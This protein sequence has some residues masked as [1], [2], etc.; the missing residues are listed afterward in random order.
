MAEV[1]GT[2]NERSS[3][4][5]IAVTTHLDLDDPRYAEAAAAIL[6]RHDLYEAEANITSAV[7]DFLLVT[8]LVSGD[9]I[10]EEVRPAEGSREAVDLTV[11]RTFIEV[12]RRI[13]TGRGA[14]PDPQNIRQ[15][16]DYLA[17]AEAEGHVFRMG[18]LTD[19]RHWLLRWPGAGPV[20]TT[21]PHAF[22]LDN[23]G[24]WFLLYEWLRDHALFS[25]TKIEPDRAHVARSFGPDSP[26]YERE[27]AAFTRLYNAGAGSATVRIKRR[28]WGDLLRAA[29]GEVA[30]RPD[31]MDDLFIR[32]TYL[33]AVIG[34]AVQASFGVDI[35]QLAQDDPA[36]LLLGQRFQNYTGLQGIVESDF[37]TWPLEV[38]GQPALRALAQRVAHFDWPHAPADTAAILYETVIPPAERRQLGEYYTPPWLAR[39]MVEEVVSDPLGQ[40]VLDPACGSGTFIAEAVTHVIDAAA[41][42]GLEPGATLDRLRASVT[43]MD[44]HPVAV[45]LARAAWALAARPAIQAAA[46]AGSTTTVSVP[47]YL[48]DAL[49]MR[50]RNGDMFSEHEVTLPVDDERNSELVFPVRLVERADAFDLLMSDIATYIEHGEDPVV[51]LDDHHIIDASE[52]RIMQTT[53]GVMRNLHAA[54]RNHIWAY[55]T[56][57]LVRPVALARGKVDVIIGNP[58]WLNYNKTAST[59]RLALE[60]QSKNLYGIWAGGRYATHQ[61]VAGLFF[62]RCVDLYLKDGGMIGMVMP[63][64]ALQTGQYSKW[65]SGRWVSKLSGIVVDFGWKTAWDLE[66]LDPNTFFPVAASVVFAR[67]IGD[68]GTSVALEGEVERWVGKAGASNVRRIRT[69]IMD[70]SVAGGSPYAKVSRQGATIV[71]RRLFF[72]EETEN[73]AIVQAGQTI[74]VKPRLSS[75]DKYPWNRIDLTGLTEQT[76]ENEHVFDVHMGETLAPYV[77]LRPLRAVLPLK[78]TDFSIARD[79]NGVGGV[80]IASLE[81]RMRNRW[82]IVSR[83]R[84]Q[85]KK[86]SDRLDAL[87]RLDFHGELS[88]QLKWR[89]DPGDRPVRVVYTSSGEP[90]AALL[91]DSDVIV[92]YKLFWISCKD[93]NEAYYLMSIIN[94]NILAVAVNKYTTPNWAGKTR[95]L[96]KQLWKLPIPDFDPEDALHMDIVDAGQAAEHGAIQELGSLRESRGFTGTTS[97]IARR[98]LRRWLESSTAGREVE[99]VVS[100]LIS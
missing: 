53:I 18:V 100:R 68:I 10:H 32:H 37:F 76:I 23:P 71:P 88:A 30:K 82:R 72:V 97:R 46:R 96:Q 66:R 24:R 5:H 7:R 64:S 80:R 29:L 6:R 50:F 99:A 85:H 86:S 35:A 9:D 74:T 61:D 15:L 69:P 73:P 59:L 40:H 54:G 47:V 58:P 57:N 62:A 16:D 49:Q 25:E 52:R 63:H 95:D 31:E 83:L 93:L 34:L 89:Q 48:G 87:G 21:P 92:D 56:R 38:G 94:S 51:A 12:K 28:L 65:R 81:R 44:V 60:E 14:E 39:T 84:D 4:R 19:G 33:S 70:T 67:R 42:A 22:T 3:G 75:Q 77:T 27:K 45:H 91:H 20:R 11:L 41:R 98:E 78:H 26:L 79:E 13:G 17:Q 1:L 90:T 43:G 8:G 55:Y 2:A 36:D